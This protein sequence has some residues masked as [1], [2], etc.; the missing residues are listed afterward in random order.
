[1]S[2][3]PKRKGGRAHDDAELPRY[4]VGAVADRVGVPVPTLRS[5]NLRYGVGPAGHSPGRHRLYS[6]ADI[7]VV[8]RMREM[9]D[10]GANPGSAARAA[11]DAVVP[12]GPD[13][14][15]LITCAFNLDV[16]GAGRQLDRYLRHF[17]VVDTWEQLVRPAFAAVEAR[18]FEGEGCID[19][20]HALSWTV[21]RSL[22]RL[23]IVPD[24]NPSIILACTEN[25]THTLA[26][27]ALRAALGDRGRGALM[28]G[29]DVPSAA[30]IDAVERHRET[31]TVVLWSQTTRTA[32]MATVKAVI[33]A[34]ALLMVGGPGW[35]SARLPKQAVRLDSLA[36]AVDYL[37]A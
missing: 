12:A 13:A 33:G 28:L 26:L 10:A 25:E 16:V 31:V 29:A 37:T 24:E 35:A 30:V 1:M 36:T 5:W 23:P 20:E 27:E 15:S 22:Q 3:R 6:E 2:Q 8:E 11:L 19:V 32:H 17:G 18:Q 7:A 9:I 34:D 21:S 14:A 4:T